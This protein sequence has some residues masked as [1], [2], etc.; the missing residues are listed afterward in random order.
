MLQYTYD[1]Y[2]RVTKETYEDG[3]TVSYQYDNNG[4]L[5]TVTDSATG[6]T[7]TYYYD[8]TDRLM[9]Y[10]ESGTN[11]SHSVGYEYDN[12]NNLTKLVETINGVAHTST[13]TYDDDNRI[14]SKTTDGIG[15]TYTY[16]AYGRISGQ[17]VSNNGSNVM[18]KALTY[19][20]PTSALT[21][22]Q[23]A[24]YSTTIGGSTYT[25]SYTYDDNGNILTVSDGTYTTTYTY[26]TANQLKQEVNEK[27]KKTWN[28]TYDNAGNITSRTETN[29]NT[30]E[31]TTVAYTY[32]DSAWGDLLTTYNGNTITHDEVGNMLSDGTWTYT[33]DHGRELAS[34]TDGTNTWTFTYGAN[35]MRTGRTN[36]S[37]TYS[38]VYNGDQL[39]QL[40]VLY[41]GETYVF[42]FNY[43]ASGIPVSF[44]LN[45]SQ[46]YYVTNQ[47]GDVVS[48]V[49]SSGERVC[50]YYYTAWNI[51]SLAMG[52][53]PNVAP[54]L[55]FSPFT[56]RGYVMDF[57]TGLF[58]LQSRYYN[59]AMGRFINADALVS[60]GQG[61][62]GNNMFAYCANNPASNYDPFGRYTVSVGLGT[63]FTAFLGC[64]KC[65]AIA[66]D[67][68][69][70]VEIQK[71]TSTPRNRETTTVGLFNIGAFGFVQF[72][73]KDDVSELRNISTYI[74]V[75]DP[76]PI[77]CDIV[78]D[79]P[80]ADLDGEAIGVQFALGIGAG[81]DIH[82]SQSYTETI[83]RFSW[84]ELVNWVVEIFP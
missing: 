28:W 13:Y 26:D 75:S 43:D 29:H 34:M 25:Y 3:D 10:V 8:F 42:V 15:S 62:L 82:I 41:D 69:G 51:S 6:I 47:Q 38:Y 2:G 50:G 37:T 72:T 55:L 32:G 58:Y 27:A 23:I 21:S 68:N 35:G 39:S 16:D 30:N 40:T 33:W 61:M 4:A 18:T 1:K 48:V 66:F 83:A 78:S 36:G 7:T 77:G 63:G 60:T 65:Y 24:T 84:E 52:S 70:N 5:A 9:K 12:I 59:A 67:G 73:E 44:T 22:G 11:Y 49:N 80:A 45:G 71:S 64:S 19:R 53:D 31:T 54:I 56:Y 76:L 17:T 79:A 46:Y 81:V 14:V 20:N 57:E 74:G